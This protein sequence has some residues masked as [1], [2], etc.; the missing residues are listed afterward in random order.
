MNDNQL[1]LDHDLDSISIKWTVEDVFDIAE[2]MD[3]G[4]EAAEARDI[5]A[6]LKKNHDATIGINHNVI[7]DTIEFYLSRP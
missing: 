3:I 5:L 4:L 6:L 7:A 1:W 2:G